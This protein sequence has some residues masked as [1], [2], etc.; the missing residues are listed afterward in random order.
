M[1]SIAPQT[2]LAFASC[3]RGPQ[4]HSSSVSSSTVNLERLGSARETQTQCT[5]VGGRLLLTAENPGE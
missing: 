3:L 5:P 4:I 2:L 1:R